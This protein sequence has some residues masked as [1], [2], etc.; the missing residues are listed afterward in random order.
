MARKKAHAILD[1][2]NLHFQVTDSHRTTELWK[3]QG[4]AA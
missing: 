1:C 2:I 3:G 4:E